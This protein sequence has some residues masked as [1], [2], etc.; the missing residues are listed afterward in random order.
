MAKNYKFSIMNWLR[1]II[2]RIFPE[3]LSEYYTYKNMDD[4][5]EKWL[6][7]YYDEP[8]WKEKVH[9]KTLN[10]SATI[11]SEFA[12]LIMV[13][14]DINVTGSKRADFISKQ[15]ARVTAHLRENLEEACAVG[16]IMFKPYVNNG[17]VLTDCITQDRFV[18]VEWTDD[19]IT[20]AIF[21]SKIVKGKFYYFRIEKQTYDPKTRSHR[22]R[23][24]FFRSK[25]LDNIGVEITAKEYPMQ[26]D[27]DY[28][29]NDVDKPLFS[30]WRVP[31][32]NK[33]DKESPLG[34]SVYSM[35]V[36]LIMEADFQWDRFLWEFEGGELAI[37]AAESALRTR[38]ITDS[39]GKTATKYETPKTKDR[40]FRKLNYH[41]N[42]DK[43]FYE[44]FAPALRDSAYG[45]GLDKILRKIEFAC[46]LAYGTLSDP[47]NVDKTAEEVKSG[48]Q[49]SYDTVNNMQQSLQTA[50]EDYIYAI[51]QYVSACNLSP[52]GKLEIQWNWGD[53]VLE[54]S[55]KETQIR[56][57]E[58]N[59]NIVDKI[60]YLK[61]RYGCTDEQ[62]VKM[63]PKNKGVADFFH[64]EEDG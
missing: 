7:L 38:S 20:S 13:E 3:D 1:K 37:D 50:L 54:D 59:S 4:A 9:E 6:A 35:A 31:T 58:V 14:F 8:P 49:R 46:A 40:L 62:A 2:N 47:Q 63:M 22:V 39:S 12:R 18:P 24:K 19:E 32:A 17:V 45:N 29:I 34:V 43:P 30:F 60:E 53:G 15:F 21:I 48:K 56:L 57:Q 5:I 23:S 44:I 33:I 64:D 26:I 10:L 61:W 55:D 25:Q 11:A 16:G 51:D 28:T 27:D 41:S 36:K 42:S 52:A